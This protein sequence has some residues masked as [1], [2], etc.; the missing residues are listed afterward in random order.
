MRQPA[1]DSTI[2]RLTWR[3]MPLA[4]PRHVTAGRLLLRAGEPATQVYLIRRGQVR[5]CVLSSDGRETTTAVLGTGQLVGISPLL[6]R[7]TYHEFAHALGPVDVWSLPSATLLQSLPTNPD[8]LGLVVGALGQRLV[9]GMTL[10][11]DVAL[12]TV[13]NRVDD[14]RGLLTAQ[15]GEPPRLTQ[16]L[17]SDL[18]GARPETLSRLGRAGVAPSPSAST[19]R[20]PFQ[21]TRETPA[22]AVQSAPGNT[23][24]LDFAAVLAPM[25]SLTY[26]PG[27]TCALDFAGV[28]APMPS[29]SY[30][31]GERIPLSPSVD[32]VT[33]LKDG[34]VRLLVEGPGGRRMIIDRIESGCLELPVVAAPVGPGLQAEAITPASIWRVPR[35]Q[36]LQ[37][38]DAHPPLGCQVLAQTATRL[39][40]VEQL[41]HRAHAPSVRA[42]LASVML[43]LMHVEGSETLVGSWSVPSGWTHEAFAHAVGARRET[44][45]RA[46]RG[47]EFDGYLLRSGARLFVCEPE[48]LARD[49]GAE[50]M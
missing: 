48:R 1:V 17:L 49:F 3:G 46:L 32:G 12:K 9:Q 34:Q 18:V 5:V 6:G 44:V 15:L 23:S 30:A 27:N 19:P 33:V 43:E 20:E 35:I 39:M 21:R 37:L 42:R 11:G 10:L 41:L 24:A 31:P 40:R 29:L 25:P 7:A 28:L 26:A 22:P 2:S 16:R 4:T 8:L 50:P 47:L 14:I 45:T 13:P 36:L 38:L